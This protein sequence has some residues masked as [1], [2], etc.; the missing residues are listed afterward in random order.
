MI[1][2]EVSTANGTGGALSTVP[3][4]PVGLVVPG[5]TKYYQYWYRD[6]ISSPCGALFN[7]TN[8]LQVAWTN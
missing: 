4:G 1:R 6:P 8:G 2:L 3:I 7:L 5:E